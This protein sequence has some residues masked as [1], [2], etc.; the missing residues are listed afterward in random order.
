MKPP[1]LNLFG[2]EDPIRREIPVVP[3]K[4]PP[5]TATNPL[6]EKESPITA[7]TAEKSPTSFP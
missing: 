2:M 4:V 7:P 1:A 3:A 6:L 5:E